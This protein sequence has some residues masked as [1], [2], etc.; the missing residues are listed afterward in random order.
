MNE[1]LF[2]I[3]KRQW[4]VNFTNLQ[5]LDKVNGEMALIM[6]VYSMWYCINPLGIGLLL[7][8]L[9]RWK[10]DYA[11]SISFFQRWSILKQY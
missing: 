2:G 7:E 11:K 4:D 3:I 5:E 1:H 6:T 9:K 8:K 10:P